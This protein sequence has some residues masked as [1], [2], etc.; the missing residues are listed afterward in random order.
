M[1]ILIGADFV[2]TKSNIELFTAGNTIELFG[3]ELF[4]LLVR[5]D[6]R[7]FNLEI[8]LADNPAPISKWGPSLIAPTKAVN[9]YQKTKV[10]LLTIANNHIMDQGKSGLDSTLQTL[11]EKGIAHV[12]AGADIF[13]AK[14]PYTFMIN[15]KKIGVYA[16]TEHEFSIAD[17]T[18]C[19]ANPFDA[20]D[21]LDHVADLKKKCDYAIVLYHGGKEYYRY[22]SPRLQ[23]TCR[24][25]VEKG[26]DLVVCQHSHCI[27]CEEEYQAGKI[28]YGQ[29]N[30]LFDYSESESWQTG[31]LIEVT[32]ELT[33]SYH[34]I[35]KHEALV[36]LADEK[37][38][39]DILAAFRARSQ[40]IQKAGFIEEKYRELANEYLQKYAIVLSNIKRP[41]A[42]RIINK[43]F[44]YRIDIWRMNKYISQSRYGLINY[45]EC[46][47][48]SEL[49]LE[50][51]KNYGQQSNQ[52][53]ANR[54]TKD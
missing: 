19:G 25:L 45:I 35:V 46:E 17:T 26:A 12:G 23:K 11:D 9:L 20:L 47:A 48:H 38:R 34:P 43:L 52:S 28:V 1:S 42:Y 53:S 18:Q 44:A 21:S 10:D 30:F 16:C 13:D 41:L 40:E 22:P 32:D 2:P 36:R 24:K 50:G 37:Q 51:L 15:G 29:G 27:G 8:P 39:N 7:I 49:L 31:L 3:S 4:N 5:A 33:I 14:K 6:Y 54:I